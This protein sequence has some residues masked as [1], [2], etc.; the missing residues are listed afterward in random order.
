MSDISRQ[1]SIIRSELAFSSSWSP[2]QSSPSLTS[3]VTT[4][5]TT[6]TSPLPVSRTLPLN[7]HD[8]PRR[9][10]ILVPSDT[11][12]QGWGD[13]DRPEKKRRVYARG[14]TKFRPFERLPLEVVERIFA[15]VSLADLCRF[16]RI[17][18]SFQ[19]LL[20]QPHIYSQ[21]NLTSPLLPPT[22]L[23][24]LPT[25]LPGVQSLS[26]PSFPLIS[27]SILLPHVTPRLTVLDLS[28]SGVSDQ[29]IQ[30]LSTVLGRVKVVRLKGCRGVRD[31]E[32]LARV[33][34][35]AQWVDLSWSGVRTLPSL[36]TTDSFD[37]Y[38][39]DQDGD[40]ASDDLSSYDP[41]SD[42]SGFFESLTFAS[43]S[44][45]RKTTT[46]EEGIWSNLKRLSL[47]SCPHLTQSSQLRRFLS[48]L[49]AQLDSLDLSHLR[50]DFSELKS[51][52]F[53]PPLDDFTLAR[54]HHHH[55]QN[56][57]HSK[58]KKEIRTF[59]LN[60]KGNDLLTR[61]AISQLLS[62]WGKRFG[63]HQLP[64]R[65]RVCGVDVVLEHD[66]VLESEGEE[67]VRRF[68]EMVAGSSR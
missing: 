61:S 50:V 43:A 54:H 46:T 42:D 65:G 27:L 23:R 66:A 57:H 17:S 40:D 25:I 13:D 55:Q 67:D 24:L 9:E 19:A 29:L 30:D 20:L 56:T 47:S 49:P 37:N 22:L 64:Q 36:S 52:A 26:L 59:T 6:T 38:L 32:G 10:V 39:H 44:S 7:H 48:A 60:L 8:I 45:A 2:A 11:H 63:G 3:D 16:K 41:S 33:T 15:H 1:K 31:G 34:G 14:E 4:T 53:V 18:K 68:V 12:S 58:K 21:I 51:M 62:V 28:F 5:T 35:M